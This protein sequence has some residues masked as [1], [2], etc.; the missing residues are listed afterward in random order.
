MG[1]SKE[2][3]HH[4]TA[5]TFLK[6][7]C[8]CICCIWNLNNAGP[9]GAMPLVWSQWQT[10]RGIL[11]PLLGVLLITFGL[12]KYVCDVVQVKERIYLIFKC[13]SNKDYFHSYVP[14]SS[15]YS[16]G[17]RC[18]LF[19]IVDA[20]IVYLA[21][22]LQVSISWL[23]KNTHFFLSQFSYQKKTVAVSIS[24]PNIFF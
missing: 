24:H 20:E 14:F 8:L 4:A 13:A 7:Q 23:L 3:T 2:M 5:P 15:E 12:K 9:T 10:G 18:K 1:H 21:R 6:K 11:Y 16:P 19:Q 17:G 22:T